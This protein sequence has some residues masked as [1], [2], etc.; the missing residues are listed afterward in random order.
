MDNPWASPWTT[1]DSPSRNE[2]VPPSP[3]RALLSP[4]PRALVGS[5]STSPAQSPWVEDDGFRDWLGPDSTPNK[6]HL[7]DLGVW[8]DAASLRQPSP[9]PRHDGSGRASPSPLAW[10]SST[11]TSPGLKPLPRS[12]TSS[13]FRGNSPDPWAAELSLKRRDTVSS[14]SLSI[15]EDTTFKLD[16][17]PKGPAHPAQLDIEEEEDI[18][19]LGIKGLNLDNETAPV[20]AEDKPN[21]S[22]VQ[23]PTS[24]TTIAQ[25]TDEPEPTT[26]TKPTPGDKIPDASPRP[27]STF[28]RSVGQDLDR[29]DSPITSIDEDPKLNLQAPPRKTTGKVQEL[30][31]KYDDLTKA[32]I[33]EPS[34][35]ERRETSQRTNGIGTSAS[36]EETAEGD[37]D[38]ADFGDFEDVAQ[39]E[40]RTNADANS[41]S[42]AP[43]RP[44]TPAAHLA[45]DPPPTPGTNS[46]SHQSPFTKASAA[47]VAQLL[48]KFGPIT[49]DVDP[50]TADKLFP[51]ADT[52][53][54]ET[55]T[56]ADIPDCVITNTFD[57]ISERKAWYRISRYGSKRKHDSGHGE[58]YHTVTWPGSEVRGDT[59]KIVRRWMEEDSYT[60]RAT[61]GGSKRTSVFNWD[62]DSAAPV[63][64]NVVFGRKAA[65]SRKTSMQKGHS[66]TQSVQSNGPP[67]ASLSGPRVSTSSLHT[68]EGPSTPIANFGW[69]SHSTKSPN[70]HPAVPIENQRQSIETPPIQPAPPAALSARAKAVPSPIQLPPSLPVK[71]EEIPGGGDEDND[72]DDDDDDDWGEMVSSPVAE[73]QPSIEQVMSPL[74]PGPAPQ[75]PQSQQPAAGSPALPNIASPAAAGTPLS[76]ADFSIFDAP[77]KSPPITQLQPSPMISPMLPPEPRTP[78]EAT[79]S[80]AVAAAAPVSSH[81]REAQVPVPASAP[82]PVPPK[83]ALQPIEEIAT[84][85]EQ[86]EI[87]REIVRNLPDLSYMLR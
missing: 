57:T 4:P 45:N 52:Q 10:P 53:Q 86:D 75:H 63:D 24:E 43:D 11:A 61:L 27:S 32:S 6:K 72:N 5:L 33:A 70:L 37:D 1:T 69:N 14:F 12:R 39:D 2:L 74:G 50:G 18:N 59:M 58:G 62:L 60:G 8:G 17:P 65:H 67:S 80:A 29:Q 79:A 84:E 3:P 41:N 26:A 22:R 13:I 21:V 44:S 31:G 73:A 54:D 48:E 82:A 36:I 64:L 28:S 42:A 66:A 83:S 85:Q 49:F 46:T 19:G 81:T 30:V 71:T 55:E 47:A 78:V 40:G 38:G 16:N 77:M 35:T 76:F 23:Q 68:N 7:S 51:A 56:R 15:H 9:T 20:I 87:V 34:L 25:A